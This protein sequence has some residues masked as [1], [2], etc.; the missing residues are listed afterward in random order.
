MTFI[1]SVKT[2]KLPANHG[3]FG[4]EEQEWGQELLFLT[5]PLV[6][7]DFQKILSR[8]TLINEVN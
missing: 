2:E 5:A 6:L 4:G 7:F 1:Y 8:Y 3:N